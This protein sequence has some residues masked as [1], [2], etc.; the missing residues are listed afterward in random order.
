M[1]TYYVRTDGSDSNTGLG[2]ASNQAWASIGKALGATGIS[3]GDT[4]YIA[5][6][7]YYEIVTANLTSPTSETRII[8]NPTASQFAGVNAGIVRWTAFQSD[9][10]DDTNTP[11]LSATSK[12][13]LTFEN[14]YIESNARYTS[15]AFNFT[16]CKYI[17]IRNCIFVQGGNNGGCLSLTAPAAVGS[18][19]IFDRNIFIGK[20]VSNINVSGTGSTNYDMD[21]TIANNLS[22]NLYSAYNIYM[23]GT[24][25]GGVQIFNN[26]VL[27]STRPIKVDTISNTTHKIKLYNNLVAFAGAE[28]VHNGGSN[29]VIVGDYNRFNNNESTFY[30]YTQGPRDTIYG[31]T[32]LSFGAERFFGIGADDFF[33]PLTSS[34][35]IAA[36]EPN[37]TGVTIT[38]G[39]PIIPASGVGKTYF[40]NDR[41]QFTESLGNISSSAIYVVSA[42]Y[43][44]TSFALDGLTPDTNGTL[45]HRRYRYTSDIYNTGWATSTQPNVG[46]IEKYNF[47][48]IG[49]YNPTEKSNNNFKLVADQTQQSINVYLGATGISYNS[50]G[51]TAYYIR[52]NSS[53]VSIGLTYNNPTG[54]WISGGFS[55]IS[56]SLT[57]GLYRVDLP[58][59]VSDSGVDNVTVVIRGAVGTNGA[60]ANCQIMPILSNSSIANTVWTYASRTIT[61]GIAD[62]VT[63]LTTRSGFAITNVS[64][65]QSGLSTVT[66]NQIGAS[67]GQSISDVGLTTIVTGRID[68]SVSSRLA[69]ASYT[70]PPTEASIAST[71]W[72]YTSRTI[73]GGIANTV[74]TLT[75]R[76]GFATTGG[77][78]TS[79]SSPVDI[80]TSSMSGIA[81]S[82]WT[83]VTRTLSATGISAFDVWNYASR[84]L[85]AASGATAYEIWNFNNRTLSSGSGISAYDVWNYT[86]RI[87]TGGTG[88]SINQSFPENFEFMLITNTGRIYLNKA[89]IQRIRI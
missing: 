56:S 83:N 85:T 61:G 17:K 78:I 15:A 9:T 36:G 1:P 14:L 30:Q 55:E 21:I 86:D 3:S 8:G 41:I 31:P 25:G 89:D 5:P 62:T 35:N 45:I 19:S 29:G 49:Y 12:D 54:S 43:G 6:G 72:T 57:P 4:V 73:T 24:Y 69:S 88:V 42:A 75:N 87:I 20:G 16:T 34:A 47:N 71:V 59:A 7:R 68:A 84:T 10:S 67:I 33:A 53:P 37:G 44:S 64:E 13:Y 38:A 32:G 58:N 80:T 51:L 26:T 63:V 70:I 60:Y 79:V 81:N 2:P 65:I 52:Q 18:T 76:S 11:N 39:N 74:T 48:T 27:G 50:S 23:S 28:V 22:I 66:I 77:I 82:V 40:L 46:N